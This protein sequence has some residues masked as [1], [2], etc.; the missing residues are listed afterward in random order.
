MTTKAIKYHTLKA[1]ADLLSCS[2][3]QIYNYVAADRIVAVKMDGKTLISDEEIA[4]F[5]SSL[6]RMVSQMRAPG[7]KP[8]KA[9]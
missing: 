3:S 1:A 9:A 2:V 4:R 8:G 7:G 6:P 5:Q